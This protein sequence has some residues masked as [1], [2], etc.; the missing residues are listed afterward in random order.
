MSRANLL[1]MDTVPSTHD[2]RDF[3]YKAKRSQLRETVD[4]RNWDSPVD[5]QKTVGSCVGNAI[6]S[7]YEL[8]VK[9][10]YPEQFVE[11]SRLFIY[12]NSRLFDNSIWH[13]VGTYIRDGLK[14]ASRYGICSEELWPYIDHFY[15][16]QPSPECYVDACR[17]YVTKYET[18]YNTRDIVDVINDNRP[19]VV[20]I[21]LYEGFMELG[22][23]AVVSR[24]GT[25]TI[26]SHAVVLLGYDTTRQM[27]LAKNSFGTDWGDLGYFWISYEYI[28]TQAFERWCFDISSQAVL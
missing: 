6:A 12:Y 21:T 18:L 24:R 3:R 8:Q 9:R 19:V 5:D 23:N 15:D 2:H 25:T 11:L 10:L 14:A 28:R 4:L 26:G 22:P 27:F 7:A 17:R 20:G 16:E 13:D 1:A